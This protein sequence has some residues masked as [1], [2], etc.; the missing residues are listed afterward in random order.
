MAGPMITMKS[1][2]KKNRTIGTVSLG[3]KAGRLLLG[4]CHSHFAGLLGKHPQR[5]AN[6][7]AVALGLN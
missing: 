2:G 1:T 6:R 7:R 3:P 5:L 4:L